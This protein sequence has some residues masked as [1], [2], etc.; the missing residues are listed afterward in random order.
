M[1]YFNINNRRYLGNKFRL[2][3]FIR[4]VVE[5]NCADVASVFDA[6]SGTGSVSWAFRDKRLVV[7]D[8]MY[9][10]YLSALTWFSPWSVDFGKLQ[11]LVNDYNNL[12]TRGESNYMS[13]NFADTYFSKEVCQKIGY[14]R[15]DVE[16][17]CLNGDVN[18]RERAILITSLIYAM[19]K[20]AA[21]CGHYDAYRKG[22]RLPETLFLRLSDIRYRLNA[23]NECFNEDVNTLAPRVHCDLVYLDPPYNSRQYCDTYH[24]LENVAQWKKPEVK[25][26]AKKM[27]RTDMKSAY[28]TGKAS[29]EFRSLIAS[30]DCR[31]IL[32]SYNSTGSVLNGRS[33][34]KISDGVILETLSQK[35]SVQVFN[36]RYPGF[37]TGLGKNDE[38]IE[39]LF[40]CRVR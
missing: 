1:E 22:C 31:Y 36:T 40:L 33:N 35:G 23:G 21:T 7:N 39:R 34:A 29:E 8:L 18:E 9:C 27:D 15:D 12:D 20:V 11:S 2:L 4:R 19:D 13:E 16:R 25:G 32:L 14:V 5:E 6:F 17:L 28:C 3:P 30:L 38:N 10:N 26:I 37:T 24:I